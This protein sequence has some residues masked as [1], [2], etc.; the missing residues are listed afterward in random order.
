M[1]ITRISDQLWGKALLDMFRMTN[2]VK[3]HKP[4][5]HADKIGIRF[6]VGIMQGPVRI[7]YCIDP[8][9]FQI[10]TYDELSKAETYD[11]LKNV[12]FSIKE[13]I[14]LWGLQDTDEKLKWDYEDKDII[15]GVDLY[16][17]YNFAKHY[18]T[19]MPDMGEFKMIP[20]V[21]YE[22]RPKRLGKYCHNAVLPSASDI[23][24][25]IYRFYFDPDE[26]QGFFDLEEDEV[27]T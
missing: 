11:S 15:D 18:L 1:A 9:P 23:L 12:K 7:C 14:E 8:N 5:R 22:E 17:K 3:V 21:H 13:K 10:D 2:G 25:D 6:D 19:L 26:T 4:I 20:D 27:E 24:A 16:Q